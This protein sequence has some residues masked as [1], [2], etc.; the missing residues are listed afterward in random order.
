VESRSREP[1]VAG[2]VVEEAGE[3]LGEPLAVVG[4]V[5]EAQPV[6]GDALEA[7]DRFGGDAREDL[8]EEVVGESSL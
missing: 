1:V 7:A 6:V 2:G 3:R 4:V 5:D 8:D